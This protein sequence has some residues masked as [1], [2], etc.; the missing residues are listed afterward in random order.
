MSIRVKCPSCGKTIKAD[1]Y[2]AGKLAACP[3]CGAAVQIPLPA[4]IVAPNQLEP[5]D[6]RLSGPV[7]KKHPLVF[8]SP[9]E[10]P[11]P[12]A[13]VTVDHRHKA[14]G[15]AFRTGFGIMLGCL[16]AGAVFFIGGCVV[17]GL[18][19]AGMSEAVDEAI[20]ESN[21]SFERDLAEAQE[22]VERQME[23]AERQVERE[24]GALDRQLQSS[25]GAT[26]QTAAGVG[27]DF[28]N[29][30]MRADYG[31]TRV[32]GE[33]TNKS[34]RSYSMANFVV[35]LYDDKGKLLDTGNAIVSNLANGQTK[36]FEADFVGVSTS[37]VDQYKIQ[38]DYGL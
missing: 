14:S 31:L 28:K 25:F 4:K 7:S 26:P 16:T 36:S 37:Q 23:Q 27:F 38:F 30:T 1:D 9:P 2:W 8:E 5:P 3:S 6:D 18:I 29:V 13:H 32:I 24:M 22:Y 12:T 34:G 11:R 10:P 19:G 17:L 20:K 35:T 15:G 33:V 21:A